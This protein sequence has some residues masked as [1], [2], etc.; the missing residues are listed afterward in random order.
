MIGTTSPDLLSSRL[1]ELAAISLYQPYQLQMSSPYSQAEC[2]QGKESC[3][4]L[5][6]LKPNYDLLIIGDDD[7]FD[8]TLA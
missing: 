1:C 6:Y 4:A 7:G 2:C 8:P 5:E 3:D